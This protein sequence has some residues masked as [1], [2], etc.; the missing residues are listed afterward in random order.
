MFPWEI[1]YVIGAAVL[2]GALAWGLWRNAN[3]NKA[4]DA[5]TEEATRQEYDHPDTY[6][7]ERRENLKSQVKPS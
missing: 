4:N 5:V 1:A 7:D 2:G 6:M 3:R